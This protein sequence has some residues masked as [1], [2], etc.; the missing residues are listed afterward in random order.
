MADN[1]TKAN[2]VRGNAVFLYD[3]LYRDSTAEMI[4]DL[5]RMV[6]EIRPVTEFDNKSTIKSPYYI[7][8]DTPVIDVFINSPGGGIHTMNSIMTFL[9]IAR[10][11]GAIIRTTITG[12]TA[13]CASMIAIQ[14]TAGFRIMYNAS[15]NIIH[16]GNSDISVS[17][18]GEI[19]LAAK[20]EKRYRQS[21]K[22]IYKKFTDMTGKEIDECM[23]TEHHVYS[24]QECLEKNMC[25]WVLT[26]TSI[27]ISRNNQR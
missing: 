14:G 3:S 10:S 21:Q 13:S 27:F 7:G 24:A 18:N 16:Y 4:G 11:K 12:H 1:K 19:D 26:D 23:K 5:A 25:D 22:E 2:Y 20:N 15:Y 9:N 6:N 17:A 8:N